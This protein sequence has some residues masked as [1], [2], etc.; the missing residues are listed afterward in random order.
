[1]QSPYSASVLFTKKPDRS[2]RLYVDYCGLNK[3]TIKNWYSFPLIS[4]TLKRINQGLYFTSMNLHDGFHFLQMTTGEKWKI[5]FHYRYE[6]FKYWVILFD[7]CNRSK[8][9]QHFT[10]DTFRDYLNKFLTIYLNDLLIYSKTLKKHK[11]HVCKVLERLCE[12]ELYVKL[13]KC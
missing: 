7:L 3:L 8:T 1:M 13:Q 5:A 11:V 10:N 9:F 4:E 6:L 12:A 2:L